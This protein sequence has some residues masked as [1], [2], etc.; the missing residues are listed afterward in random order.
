MQ[1]N[2]SPQWPPWGQKKVAVADKFKQE[3]MYGMSV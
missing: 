2:L 1:L 3:P